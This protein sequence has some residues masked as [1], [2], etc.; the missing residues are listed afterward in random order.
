MGQFV[1]PSLI[2]RLESA[3]SQ[4]SYVMARRLEFVEKD[5]DRLYPWTIEL[6]P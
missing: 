6:G 1:F 4:V 3:L 5:K 2:C